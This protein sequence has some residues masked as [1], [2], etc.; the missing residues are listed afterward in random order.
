MS[1]KFPNPVDQRVQR[2]NQRLRE[3]FISL[4][5]ERG[6]EEVT[7]RDV[8]HRAAVGRSTFYTHFG[9]L[10]ELH[11][12]WLK[13]F[14]APRAG[15]RPLLDFASSFLEHARHQR[16]SW[17][18][19]IRKSRGAAIQRRFRHN[20]VAL[21]KEE[22]RQLVPHQRPAVIDV[23]SR[24]LAGAFA[25]VLF[26]WIDAPTNFSQPELAELFNRLTASV[27]GAIQHPPRPPILAK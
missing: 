20:L 21:A 15:G 14:S 4:V 24:Y 8:V 22:V 25:E 27:L 10:E 1:T 18:G 16:G 7:I 17:H 11:D 5:H 12:Q 6:Y 13:D 2:T 3:S 9:D 23:T 19:L 26:W